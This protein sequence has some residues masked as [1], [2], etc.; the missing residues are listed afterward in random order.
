MIAVS[1]ALRI[2]LIACSLILLFFVLRHIKKAGLEIVDSVF[3]LTIAF[4]LIVVAIFPQIAYWASGLLGFDAPVNFIF[5]CG[6]LVL[7]VR[8]FR[9]D[10]KICEL[11]KKLVRMAQ[12]EALRSADR[13]ND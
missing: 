12:S 7:L 3:W 11:K 5:C 4:L 9:Q 1:F 6:I 10:Q 13:L 8:T 2:V